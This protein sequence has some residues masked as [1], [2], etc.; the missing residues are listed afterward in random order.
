MKVIII[1][2][3]ILYFTQTCIG[4]KGASELDSSN[5][6]KGFLKIKDNAIKSE[7]AIFS[8]KGS[9]L[10]KSYNNTKEKLE[11]IPLKKHTDSSA[12]FEKGNLYA[13]EVIVSIYIECR[14]QNSK[15]K[16]INY[17]HYKYGLSLPDSAFKDLNIS[18]LC[19]ESIF[20]GKSMLAKCKVFRTADKKRVYIYMIYKE[21]KDAYEVTW[22]ISDGKYYNRV[23][24][25][26]EN[27][28]F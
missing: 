11:E 18:N 3:I 21:G 7:I 28:D 25:A 1:L 9:S 17:I 10:M 19:I 5:T 20:K 27:S 16:E 4:Q 2:E 13:S 12:F 23:I 22:I 26:L 14:N 24:D 8:I 15:I 6:K